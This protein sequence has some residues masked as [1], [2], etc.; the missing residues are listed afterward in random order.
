MIQMD[1]RRVLHLLG[2]AAAAGLAGGCSGASLGS[3]DKSK[4]AGDTAPVKIG[5]LVP[6]S[7]VYKS[8]GDDMKNAFELYIATHDYKFGGRPV[9][10]V[11]ADEGETADFGKA[12]ADRL[13]KQEKVLAVSGVVNSAV[14]NAVKGLFEEA[15]IPLVG[16]N[17]SP[18]DL[19]GMKYIW[20][21][22]YVNDEPGIALGAHVASKVD[23][24]VY[25][26][27][28]DYAAG[29]DEVSGFKSTFTGKVAGEEYTPFPGTTNF[30]PYLSKIKTA[31]A[32]AV[33]CFYA[34]SAAVDFVKQYK[35]FGLGDVPLYAPGFL[36]EGGALKGQ[37][38]AAVGVY[39]SMNYSADLDNPAN[40]KFAADYRTKAGAPP[41]TYAMASFDAAA[42]L[43]KAIA[44]AGKDVTSQSLAQQIGKVSLPDSPRGSWQ[45]NANGTPKQKWYLRQVRK[46]GDTL[47]NAVVGDLPTLG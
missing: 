11:V 38:D 30:Q 7:G 43:D 45:F 18:T 31:G 40:K 25:L 10:V 9:Q 44:A 42:V 1:R 34:G 12:A 21:T 4:A 2:A 36:T 16:A 35:Q 13:I 41:T 15:Q 46:D 19:K 26:L 33:F 23:G 22:S 17:A 20:R 28:A 39:T 24:P 27:A 29:K 8:L 5:L 32:K 47:A 6:Q 37:G 14:M 3:D